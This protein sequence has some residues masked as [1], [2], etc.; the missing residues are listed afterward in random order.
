M[1]ENLGTHLK[2]ITAVWLCIEL[3]RPVVRDEMLGTTFLSE[4]QRTVCLREQFFPRRA[5]RKGK[6]CLAFLLGMAS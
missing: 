4:P 5:I 3:V 6:A 1:S 2:T